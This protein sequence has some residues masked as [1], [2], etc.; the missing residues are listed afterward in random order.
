MA[1]RVNLNDVSALPAG[2]L[3]LKVKAKASGYTDSA[4]SST[5]TITK[6]ATPTNPSASGTD[7]SFDEVQGADKYEFF[8]NGTSIGE[9]QVQ[10]N[11]SVTLDLTCSGAYDEGFTSIGVYDGT[12]D[13]GT[14]LAFD[15]YADGPSHI[16]ETVTCE[17]G[18]LYIAWYCENSDAPYDF[19][20]L[21]TGSSNC[22]ITDSNETDAEN[23]YTIVAL[24]ASPATVVMSVWGNLD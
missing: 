1:T 16:Q 10:S 24:S 9:Y 21:K 14:R 3:T 13:A 23:A 11:Y 15:S 17:T 20:A 7:V 19:D 6:L 22:T 4:F 8:A 5:V 12:S 18:N 2:D